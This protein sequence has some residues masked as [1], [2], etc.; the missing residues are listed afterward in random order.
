[1]K[2]T[3]K[4]LSFLITVACILLFNLNISAGTEDLIQNYRQQCDSSGKYMRSDPSRALTYATNALET[5]RL[6]KDEEKLADAY[7]Q[8]G[9]IHRISGNLPQSENFLEKAVLLGRKYESY[10]V[11]LKES[12]ITLKQQNKFSKSLDR[13]IEALKIFEEKKMTDEVAM[14]YNNIGRL[15]FAM[16]DNEKAMEYYRKSMQLRKPENNPRSYGISLHNIGAVM[17][18]QNRKDSA[19]IYYRKALLAYETQNDPILIAYGHASVGKLLPDTDSAEFHLV[20]SL[21]IRQRL[22]LGADILESLLYLAEL[23]TKQNRNEEAIRLY[24]DVYEKSVSKNNYSYAFS[25]AEALAELYREQN[26]FSRSDYFQTKASEWKDSI[27]YQEKKV[28][29]L[30]F[31]F[32]MKEIRQAEYIENRELELRA[33]QA[34]LEK[35]QQKSLFRTTILIFSLLIL[36]L[37]FYFFFQQQ[38]KNMELKKQNEIISQKR[39]ENE[40]LVKEVHHR[41]KNNLHTVLSMLRMEKRRKDPS[42][43]GLDTS[44]LENRI[45]NISMIHEILYNYKDLTVISLNEY[46]SAVAGN[47]VNMYPHI[48]IRLSVSGDSHTDA[49]KALYIGQMF[50]ELITNSCK[51]AFENTS[52]PEINIHI[53][54][55]PDEISISCSDN[56]PGIKI[57]SGK[58]SFGK[59]LI[60]SHGK[61]LNA[62]TTESSDNGYHFHLTL[63]KK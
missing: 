28:K 18:K 12:G 38:R 20:K 21:E 5:A 40:I 8:L 13:Y 15:H 31:D 14:M 9:I 30:G 4:P 35:E 42:S 51:H 23:R 44:R 33:S 32:R 25:S 63:K 3:N 16:N 2:L 59:K 43:V 46:L 39:A 17:E 45:M 50:S 62:I 36:A 11:I 53:K 26:N 41:V 56:G 6:L 47:I 58:D 1:M 52:H 22:Q 61:K 10:P 55:K 29:E 27:Y 49:D 19:L 54:N 7:L 34:E 60:E 24:T 57:P 48:P 37:L